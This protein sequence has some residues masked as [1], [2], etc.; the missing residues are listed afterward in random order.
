VN[1]QH[2]CYA[3]KHN[4]LYDEVNKILVRT[5]EYKCFIQI[6]KSLANYFSIFDI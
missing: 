6:Q 2:K 3:F 1:V 5:Y 4:I